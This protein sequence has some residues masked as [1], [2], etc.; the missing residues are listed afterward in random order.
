MTGFLTHNEDSAGQAP[1]P[2]IEDYLWLIFTMQRDGEDVIGARLAELLVV[3]P[4]TVTVTLK[5]MLRDGWATLDEKKH[6]SLTPEGQEAARIVLR[7]HMLVEWLL[8]EKIN[9]PWSRL[10]EEAHKLE[11]YISPDVEARLMKEL[12]Y[13]QVC[14]HGNPVPGNEE[15]VSA[16]INLMDLPV[17]SEAVIRR[18]HDQAENRSKLMSFLEDNQVLPGKKVTVL[19]HLPFNQTITIEVDGKKVSLGASTAQYI[20]VQKN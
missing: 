14:P 1:T 16:W 6:I 15:K 12:N 19:E 11:H 10:H 17:N 4:P 8:A 7:R 13:P 5:R 20:Y 3:S 9:V 2:T 18:V